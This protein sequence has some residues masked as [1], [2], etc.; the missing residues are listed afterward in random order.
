MSCGIAAAPAKK[1]RPT[2]PR[3]SR[4]RATT[5]MHAK[6]FGGV[7]SAGDN[8]TSTSS[9]SSSSPTSS[10]TSREDASRAASRALAL[11]DEA[12]D[13]LHRE[14]FVSEA[15]ARATGE[16]PE[17]EAKVVARVVEALASGKKAATRSKEE[18]RGLGSFEDEDVLLELEPPPRPSSNYD[19]PQQNTQFDEA[20]LVALGIAAAAATEPPPPPPPPPSSSSPA[21]ESDEKEEEEE[22]QGGNR[23]VARRLRLLREAV[24]SRA[25]SSLPAELRA[26]DAAARAGTPRERR[27]LVREALA[28]AVGRARGGGGGGAEGEEKDNKEGGGEEKTPPFL[29]PLKRVPP[30]AFYSAACQ[31]IDD[32]EERQIV[33]DAALLARVVLCRDDALALQ[34]G[35]GGN[36]ES[37][38]ESSSSS[39]RSRTEALAFAGFPSEL[40][41]DLRDAVSSHGAM[42]HRGGAEFAGMLVSQ[43]KTSLERKELVRKVMRRGDVLAWQGSDKDVDA[44]PTL[45]KARAAPRPGRLFAAI[46]A[47]RDALAVKGDSQRV[48][49]L[50]RARRDAVEVMEEVAYGVVR[51]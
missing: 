26:L 34:R 46:Y 37:D 41:A 50:E 16:E 23:E 21:A 27:A 14:L 36:N 35:R 15:M 6:G 2:A 1:A 51:A 18:F 44:I 32:M 24:V 7:G 42:L 3:A 5:I 38:D 10:S 12:M 29:P 43:C 28:G 33:P 49:A 40:D 48:E 31:V 25:S 4:R 19:E 8:S 45:S 39:S 30:A 47:T 17:D 11:V 13:L 20:F 9:T 22:E